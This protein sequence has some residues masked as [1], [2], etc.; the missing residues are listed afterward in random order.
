MKQKGLILAGGIALVGFVYYYYRSL[1]KTGKNLEINVFGIKWDK[2][3]TTNSFFVKVW[4][5]LKLRVNNPTDRS[6]LLK[7]VLLDFIF[8]GKKI[9]EVKSFTTYK[10]EPKK[11]MIIVIPT[12]IQ[13][14]NVVSL[15]STMIEFLKKK[16]PISI[17]VKGSVNVEGNMVYINETKKIEYP[18]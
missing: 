15:V 16:E 7:D 13:T 17:M 8:N 9:G 18:K 1:V 2:E 6:V 10:I 12:Y 3:K 11:E 14:L 4:F 5:E